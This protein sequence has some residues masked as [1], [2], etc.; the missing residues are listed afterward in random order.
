VSIWIVSTILLWCVVGVLGVVVFALAR[1]IGV[2]HERIA[3]LGA[4]TLPSA[5]KPGEAAPVLDLQDRAGHPVRIGGPAIRGRLL[6]FVSPTC[7]VCK[8]LLPVVTSLAAAERDTLDVVLAGDGTELE[9]SAIASP[10]PLVLSAEL[11]R[12]Y[13]IGKLPYAVLL[14]RHGHLTAQGLV[15]SRE[16]LES[17]LTARDLGVATIQDF[18]AREKAEI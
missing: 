9:Y 8:K 14:D 11:G 1:Q 6:F 2:L 5:L 12:R 4:L 7:P 17:L 3:P 18:I 16:Q 10:L 13:Q 15:N